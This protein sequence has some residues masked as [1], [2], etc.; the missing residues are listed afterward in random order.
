MNKDFLKNIFRRK[1]S[2][3]HV[4]DTSDNPSRKIWEKPNF[5][6]LSFRKKRRKKLETF[7]QEKNFSNCSCK[8]VESSF[9]SPTAFFSSKKRIFF[10]QYPELIKNLA[11]FSD[12]PAGKS[13]TQCQKGVAQFARMMNGICFSKKPLKKTLWTDW[14]QF[15]QSCQ[16]I[17]AKRPKVF[18]SILKEGRTPTSFSKK[19]LFFQVFPW[20]RRFQF[21][22]SC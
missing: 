11:G 20:T 6:S 21:W 18:F 17:L 4:E 12:N 7:F 5:C 10:A 16:K 8:H 15:S 3:G 14:K 22:Q 1:S 9:G 19:L 2:Y 13:S